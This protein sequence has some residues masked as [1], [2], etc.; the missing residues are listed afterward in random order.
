MYRLKTKIYI[1][2][3]HRYII[4]YTYYISYVTIKL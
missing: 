3:I 1:S 4:T 2:Y